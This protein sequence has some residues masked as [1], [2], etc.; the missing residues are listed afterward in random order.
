[1]TG[2]KCFPGAAQN[3]DALLRIGAG[4]FDRIRQLGHQFDGERIAALGTVEREKGD[5]GRLF[6]DENDWHGW[7]APLNCDALHRYIEIQANRFTIL[8]SRIALKR[9]S[10][11]NIRHD[12]IRQ[13]HRMSARRLAGFAG[14]NSDRAESEIP[15]R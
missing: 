15:A 8:D 5:L 3:Q 6:F 13:A 4:A 1:Q 11:S 7:K 9:Y 14:E 12:G 10:V 2:A